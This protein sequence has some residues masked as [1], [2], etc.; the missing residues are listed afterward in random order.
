MIKQSVIT[1]LLTMASFVVL[2]QDRPS[3][4]VKADSIIK[5]ITTE[6][7]GRTQY[8]YVINGEMQT[9][10]VVKARLYAYAPSRVEL[11][12]SS[13]QASLYGLSIIGFALSGTGATLEFIDKSG[14]PMNA[15]NGQE[16]SGSHHSLTG[17]YVL[18]GVATVLIFS[19]IFHGLSAKRHAHKALALYNQRYE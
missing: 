17:G 18:S 1:T 13:T 6:I 15:V 9:S 12:K 4:N 5:R 14:G 11:L 2:A 3:T 16:T 8:N 19:A 7:V 10:E